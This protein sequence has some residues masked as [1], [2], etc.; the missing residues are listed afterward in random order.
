MPSRFCLCGVY[1]QAQ[2]PAPTD[3]HLSILQG[4]VSVPSRRNIMQKNI[5]FRRHFLFF[6]RLYK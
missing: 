3:L 6:Y 4:R 2:R 5:N 1:G